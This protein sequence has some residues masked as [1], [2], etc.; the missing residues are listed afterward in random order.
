MTA[1]RVVVE[2]RVQGVGY[3]AWV[4]CE[5]LA[6]RLSGFVRNRRDGTVEMVF[7]GADADVRA[8]AEACGRGPRLAAVSK[9]TCLPCEDKTWERFS[10]Q[11]TL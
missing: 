3:R 10:V 11:P 1:V 2:G 8:M 9:V 4:E 5:A 7:R 6:R